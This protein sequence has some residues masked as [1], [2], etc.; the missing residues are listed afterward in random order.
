MSVNILLKM[1]AV[2]LVLVLFTSGGCNSLLLCF[3]FRNHMKAMTTM[4]NLRIVFFPVVLRQVT[5]VVFELQQLTAKLLVF[6]QTET[7]AYWRI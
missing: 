6:Y 3:G 2:K 1:L 4:T 5:I 7:W